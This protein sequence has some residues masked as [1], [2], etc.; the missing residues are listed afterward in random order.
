MERR[1]KKRE[2][3]ERAATSMAEGGGEARALP[4][5]SSGVCGFGLLGVGYRE[6]RGRVGWS[7]SLALEGVVASCSCHRALFICSRLVFAGL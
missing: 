7:R 3:G 1:G 5:R 6:P 4:R 2:V